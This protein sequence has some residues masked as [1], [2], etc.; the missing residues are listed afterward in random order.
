MR[1]S[2]FA[3]E[4]S[5]DVLVVRGLVAAAT[6]GYRFRPRTAELAEKTQR[7]ADCYRERRTA[8]ITVIFSR[9]TDAVRSFAEAFRIKK[10]P[11][12]G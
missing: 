11:S 3:V 5:I 2:P 6:E 1:S 4:S 9:P 8:V 12:D 7:L 10:G